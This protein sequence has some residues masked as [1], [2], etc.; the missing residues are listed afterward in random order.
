MEFSGM[1]EL[2]NG[3]IYDI[4]ENINKDAITWK[5]YNLSNELKM[6]PNNVME[7]N[8][9]INDVSLLGSGSSIV[10]SNE[11]LSTLKVSLNNGKIFKQAYEQCLKDKECFNNVKLAFPDQ[12]IIQDLY[13]TSN[14]KAG[15]LKWK[16]KT[17]KE[18]QEVKKK[19]R[20]IERVSQLSR[21]SDEW[22]N[23]VDKYYTK[24]LP[25]VKAHAE[26]QMN[27]EISWM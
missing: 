14:K 12:R 27:K 16:P 26:A 5:N 7:L 25:I 11:V 4:F 21:D 8:L 13:D 20:E 22:F 15:N 9:D 23:L 2:K 6:N 1:Y 3:Q 18:I 19:Q 10:K 24:T 17:K